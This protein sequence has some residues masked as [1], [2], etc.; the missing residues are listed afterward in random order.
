MATQI[1]IEQF[2]ELATHIP[3]IDVRTPA[4]YQHGHILDAVNLPLFS[5]AQR[6]IVGTIYKE[7]GRTEAVLNGLALVGP[8]L[9]QIGRQARTL[10]PD[11]RLLVHC[12]RGGMRSASMAWLFATCGLDVRSLAGGYK[13]YRRY[14]HAALQS[15]KPAIL[16]GGLTGSGKTDLLHALAREGE[17]VIDLEGLAQHRGSAFGA[18][19]QRPQPT[20][21]QFENLLGESWRR[22]NAR[23]PVWMEDESQRIGTN[24]IP[25]ALFQHMNQAPMILIEVPKAERVRRL[26]Q[27]YRTYG[28]NA[29][30]ASTLKIKKRLGGQ[31]VQAILDSIAEERY[32][33]AVATVLDYYDRTYSYTV[34]QKHQ[35]PIKRLSLPNPSAPESVL[36]VRDA[37]REFTQQQ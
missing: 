36:A 16:V 27:E 17:Q 1:E 3:V 32:A 33:E 21:E 31:R 14:M 12:W 20:N 28:A 25:D 5:D 6:A 23:L 7:Q 24:Y 26:T 30:Q 4:E 34:S 15:P 8:R 11:G 22:C 35:G 9:E 37:A 2:L 19:G 13:S 18:L 10:A 29:L